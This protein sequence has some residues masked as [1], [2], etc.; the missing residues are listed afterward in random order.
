MISIPRFFHRI[1]LGD[2]PMP[3]EFVDFGNTW[4]RHHPGWVMYT[5]NEHT[6][7]NAINKLGLK[8]SRALSGKANILRYEL[9]LRYGGIYIDTDFECLHN[10]EC[11]LHNVQCFVGLQEPGLANNAIV[12]AVPGHPFIAD[13]VYGISS[14]V[15]VF[16]S[17][18]SIKQS[19][20]Y[21]LTE[22][23]RGRSDV[24]VFAPHAFYPYRWHERWRRYERFPESYAVHHWA[25]SWRGPTKQLQKNPRKFI[26][27]VVL[28][29]TAAEPSRLEWALEGLCA[30][31]T[32]VGF[33]VLVIDHS[34]SRSIQTL[35]NTYADR[36]NITYIT[37]L[38][39]FRSQLGQHEQEVCSALCS[40][41]RVIVLDSQCVPDPD[42]VKKHSMWARSSTVVFSAHR[43]YPPQKMYSFVP[44]VDYAAFKI[45]APV[46][47]KC[48]VLCH[49]THNTTADTFTSCCM[50]MHWRTFNEFMLSDGDTWRNGARWFCGEL[51]ARGYPMVMMASDALVTWLTTER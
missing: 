33:Y 13:L 41:R 48:Y 23:L 51:S 29:N 2:K 9:L 31:D 36:L 32:E 11:L 24:T 20:P 42:V 50:S 3:Q 6:L 4:L 40:G 25:L 30:Q 39:P 46:D 12:G 44:P 34:R 15:K 45:H 22:R 47:P 49:A 43:L 10:L 27:A 38:A 14:R 7:P 19:G 35:T 16:A 26:T 8:E 18:P 28:I 21:Y 37:T 1:W 17:L 5:W